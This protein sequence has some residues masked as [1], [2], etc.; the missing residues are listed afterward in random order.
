MPESTDPSNSA[1]VIRLSLMADP[2]KCGAWRWQARRAQRNR[3]RRRHAK[4]KRPGLADQRDNK[5]RAR[6]RKRKK[7]R[8]IKIPPERSFPAVSGRCSGSRTGHPTKGFHLF[9][10]GFF[11]PLSAQELCIGTIH[12]I[13][14]RELR[15]QAVGVRPHH[16][17]EMTDD[18]RF[19]RD[20][21]WC[22]TT[23][24]Y[25]SSSFSCFRSPAGFSGCD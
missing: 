13:W 21:R 25:G 16:R 10:I 2:D 14:G 24:G 4:P 15:A 8:R 20:G 5:I 3:T 18:R 6:S 7:S 17:R 23:R 1:T 12:W 22:T 9:R 19:L 11:A